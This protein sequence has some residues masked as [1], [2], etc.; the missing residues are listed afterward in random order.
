MNSTP[1]A[2]A[3]V[4]SR[5]AVGVGPFSSLS[6]EAFVMTARPSFH[7]CARGVVLSLFHAST[8]RFFCPMGVLKRLQTL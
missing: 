2:Q 6:G 4:L 8:V 5:H 7:A 3:G 1:R